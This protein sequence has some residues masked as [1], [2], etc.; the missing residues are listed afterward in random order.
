MRPLCCHDPAI[1]ATV[2]A[3]THEELQAALSRM[4]INMDAAEAHGLLCGALCTREG[5]GAKDWLA[6]LAL[7]QG[8]AEPAADPEMIRFPGQVLEAL[9]SAEFEFEPLLPVDDAPLADRVAAL[10]A[11]CG[12]FLYGIGAGSPDPATARSGE[13]GEYL[14]DLGDIARA[15]LEPGRGGE[16]GEGDFFELVEFVRAGA[17]LAFDALAGTRAHAAG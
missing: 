3:V 16:A 11:W 17:Q 12:G 7:D 4:D 2:R 5:Y 8:A 15:E 14:R 6:E 10:A 9:Q 1:T 13:V